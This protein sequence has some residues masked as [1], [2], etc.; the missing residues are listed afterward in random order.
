[1]E[2]MAVKHAKF[3]KNP[4]STIDILD[5][6]VKHYSGLKFKE[7]I[8]EDKLTQYREVSKTIERL[9][10]AGAE[11]PDELRRLK[12]NLSQEVEAY[13]QTIA[14][15]EASVLIFNEFENRLSNSLTR[16]RAKLNKLKDSANNNKKRK[17]KRY[18]KRTS[19]KIIAKEV[20][21]A[22]REIGGAAK[23]ADV[24]EKMKLNL[25]GKYIPQ[26]LERNAQ[27]NVNWEK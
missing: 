10:E 25:D 2:Q 26:D 9:S 1:V 11:I 5:Y 27:G 24:L 21:K 4:S 17:I 23:K 22:L 16:V 19:P 6:V 20:R 14:T 18:V 12:I 13:E 7:D 15:R 8:S 3:I